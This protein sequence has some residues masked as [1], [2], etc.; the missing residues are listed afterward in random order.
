[1]G[2]MFI[3]NAPYL[4]STVWSLIK[5]WLD[6]AT[7]R[8]IHILGK[9]YKTELLKYIPAENLPENLGGTCR[10]AGG[11]SLSNAGPWHKVAQAA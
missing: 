3:I 11:C 6:E 7:Q 1:M 8:K 9:N 5:P 10:C 4:F 2:F